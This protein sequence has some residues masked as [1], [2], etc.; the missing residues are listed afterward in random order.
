MAEKN[1]KDPEDMRKAR[2]TIAKNQQ[3][4]MVSQ[5]HDG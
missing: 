5:P 2:K 3:K 1:A 4:I